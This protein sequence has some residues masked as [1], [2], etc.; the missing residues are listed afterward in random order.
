VA[1]AGHPEITIRL[2]PRERSSYKLEIEQ[3]TESARVKVRERGL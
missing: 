2:I 1:M 3:E